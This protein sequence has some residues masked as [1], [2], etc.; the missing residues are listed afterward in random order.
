MEEASETI[1]KG[2]PIEKEC[3][4]GI[5]QRIDGSYHCAQGIDMECIESNKICPMNNLKCKECNF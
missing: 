3:N 1:C 5:V 2:C 4:K